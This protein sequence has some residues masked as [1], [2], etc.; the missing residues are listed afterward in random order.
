MDEAVFGMV[1]V[2]GSSCWS[3]E[4]FRCTRFMFLT[5]LLQL[6]QIFFT[7]KEDLLF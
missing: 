3:F 1:A 7:W 4:S 2:R 5:P 6:R